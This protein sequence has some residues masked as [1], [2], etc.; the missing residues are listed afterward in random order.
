MLNLLAVIFFLHGG[1]HLV[2]FLGS[3]RLAENIPYKTTVLAGAYDVGD[4][5]IRVA[6]VAWLVT[7]LAFMV[8]AVAIVARWPWWPALSLVAVLASLLMCLVAWPEARIG[9]VLDVV[10][11]AVMFHGL[12][13]GWFELATR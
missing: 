8:A 11:L 4:A 12:R 9:A 6:G 10:L 7:A 1:A 5:G 3:W 13:F 2:G